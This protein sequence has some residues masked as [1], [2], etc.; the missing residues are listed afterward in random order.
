MG[1]AH[2]Y[3][4]VQ[5][6]QTLA[7]SPPSNTIY[8]S[9]ASSQ[10]TKTP[11]GHLPR[12]EHTLSCRAQKSIFYGTLKVKQCL[13]HIC[14]Q[15]HAKAN[16]KSAAPV[17]GKLVNTI[18]PCSQLIT[19]GV[20]ALACM[21]ADRGKWS[22]PVRFVTSILK[23]CVVINEHIWIFF[24]HV[25]RPKAVQTEKCEAKVRET[26]NAER[27]RGY[28]GGCLTV[29][30]TCEADAGTGPEAN[31]QRELGRRCQDMWGRCGGDAETCR[32]D[33]GGGVQKGAPLKRASG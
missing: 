24:F 28:A 9:V 4:H 30:I 25:V 22:P 21:P 16:N 33:S 14:M 2:A 17:S 12:P 11:L 29:R 15:L 26:L 20:S 1:G 7:V 3:H 13:Q 18:V 31:V 19:L 10:L 32:A 23:V 6:L 27:G 5:G 8:T